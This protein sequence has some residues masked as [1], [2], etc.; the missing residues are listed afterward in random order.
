MFSLSS[1]GLCSSASS[2][3]SN[4]NTKPHTNTSHSKTLLLSSSYSL[5]LFLSFPRG[6]HKA[7]LLPHPSFSQPTMAWLLYDPTL[8]H[9]SLGFSWHMLLSLRFIATL[10]LR[11]TMIEFHRMIILLAPL[12][13]M[14]STWTGMYS[15]WSH[16]PFSKQEAWNN[17]RSAQVK[18][19]WCL[20]KREEGGCRMQ[21]WQR[22][23][24]CWGGARK[25]SAAYGMM[26]KL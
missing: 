23:A 5:L 16:W 25:L 15:F 14:S 22:I 12:G 1:K 26:F 24:L 19:L 4:R 21:G 10:P 17:L 7:C 20:G 11:K 18:D 9:E 3:F 6:V 13:L 2:L 8:S